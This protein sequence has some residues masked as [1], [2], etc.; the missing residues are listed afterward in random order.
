MIHDPIVIAIDGP[1]GAGKGTIARYLS[2]KYS[3]PH[4][5]SGLLYRYGGLFLM[6]EEGD[7]GK[8]FSLESV[9]KVCDALN[10]LTPDDLRSSE[11]E[12]RMERT[13]HAASHLAVEPE[14]RQAINQWMH[15][16]IALMLKH[17]GGVIVDGR[18]I[19]TVVFPHAQVKIFV[20]ADEDVRCERRVKETGENQQKVFESMISRDQRDSFRKN[21]PLNRAS[22]AFLLDT[23]NLSIDE[24]CLHASE[25][26]T[27][28]CPQVRVHAL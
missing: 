12:L 10:V 18:D 28:R 21:A 8:Q 7:K 20:T 2:V 24:A 9:K 26:V 25:Y 1:S 23:T 4:V 3:W 16:Q 19:G 14:Y 15:H 22:D 13:A 5:D 11:Q 27:I 6:K 17:H